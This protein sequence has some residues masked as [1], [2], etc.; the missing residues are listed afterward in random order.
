LKA[1]ELWCRSGLDVAGRSGF[2]VAQGSFQ[3]GD[4]RECCG[5]LLFALPQAL[6]SQQG[7]AIPDC[8]LCIGIR[9]IRK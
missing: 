6:F 1:N 3:L 7:L 2:Q 5:K 8:T 9:R 4:P